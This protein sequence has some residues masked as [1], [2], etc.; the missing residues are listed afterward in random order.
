MTPSRSGKGTGRAAC[1]LKRPSPE[2]AKIKPRFCQVY[3]ASPSDHVARD[4]ARRRFRWLHDGSLFAVAF[5]DG[6]WTDDDEGAQLDVVLNRCVHAKEAV[7][8]DVAGA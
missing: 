8:P 1:D 5:H 4:D 2:G 3:T 7:W 6:A